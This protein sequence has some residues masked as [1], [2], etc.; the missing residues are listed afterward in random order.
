MKLDKTQ[1]DKIIHNV[2]SYDYDK[3]GSLHF[4]RFT[5]TQIESYGEQSADWLIRANASASVSFDFISD[6]EYIALKFDLYPASSQNFASFDLY[7]DNIFWQ[8]KRFE[9]YNFNLLSF[10]L[11][12]GEHRITLYFPWAANCVIKEVHL[13]DGASVKKIIKKAKTLFLGD[14]ISQGYITEFPS[15]TYVNQV[16]RDCD[17]EVVNQGVGGYYFDVN[18]IDE[19]LGSCQP[20]SIVIAYGTNDYSRYDNE[21]DF[22]TAVSK[23]I[24]KLNNLFPNVKKLAVLPIFRNDSNNNVREKY[25]NYTLDDARKIL[26]SIYEKYDSVVVLKETGIPRIPNVYASDYLHPNELGFTFMAKEI[27]KE[28]SKW[29]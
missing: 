9:N 22:E 28:I 5:K 29:L 14:S 8:H 3:N 15:L 13:T 19:S 20:N 2:I 26:T 16:A 10:D 1:I 6:S 27:E 25:R 24:H 11:P 18:S 12:K 7:V 4:R 23:Y 21:K 17:I